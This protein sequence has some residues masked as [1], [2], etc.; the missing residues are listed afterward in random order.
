MIVDL[1]L[2]CAQLQHNDIEERASELA[3]TIPERR[4]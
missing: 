1:H 2:L 4:N 3:L